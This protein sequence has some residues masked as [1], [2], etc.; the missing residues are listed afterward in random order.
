MA[1]ATAARY[2]EAAIL[3]RLAPIALPIAARAS[4]AEY[5]H[6][7]YPGEYDMAPHHELIIDHLEAVERGEIRRLLITMPPRRGKSELCS[8]RFP[9]WYLGRNPDRRIIA[10][11]HTA[12]L[13]YR[14][15]RA[16]RRQLEADAWPF[17]GVALRRGEASVQRWGL[18]RQEGGYQSAGVGGAVTGDGADVLLIDDPV[19]S[20]AQASSAVYRDMVA[21]WYDSDAMTRL[22][23]GGAVILIQTRWHED[24]LAG[25]QLDAMAAGGDQ[26][27][28]LSLP[29]IAEEGEPDALGREPGE[30][31]WPSRYPVEATRTIRETKPHVWWPL[32]QQRPSAATGRMIKRAYMSRRY[33]PTV[34]PPFELVVLTVDSAF[35]AEVGND[36][37]AW[38]VWGATGAHLYVIDAWQGRIEYPELIRAIRDA[39]AKWEHLAPW[40]YIEDAA[41]GQSAIQTL[42]RESMIPVRAWRPQGS[43][44]SRAQ[45]ASRFFAAGRVLLPTAAPWLH[46]WIEQHAAF[47]TGKHD[48]MV[49]TTSMAVSRLTRAV[50]VPGDVDPDF[51]AEVGLDVGADAPGEHKAV[52][53]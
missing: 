5:V 36:A 44:V 38:A 43:K 3:R 11:S 16:V 15:S 37:S 18:Q 22:S 6:L 33:D 35:K 52:I 48:D 29:E 41:S 53:A 42:Q 31:L 12:N 24:D 9:A 21:E 14:F 50:A 25:R 51:A 34:L 7:T 26:W 23:P 27:T 47:P 28:V 2:D 40:V 17:P 13:A 46:D 4:L 45:D 10:C 8:V 1:V 49:D 32:F 30:P 39:Y 19:K 20:R